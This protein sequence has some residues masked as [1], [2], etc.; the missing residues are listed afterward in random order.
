VTAA[1]ATARGMLDRIFPRGAIL[2]S[3]LSL[4]YFATGIIRNRVF[5]NTYG[6]G[7]ELDAYNAAFRIPEI[8]LDVLVAAGLTAP[9][10]PIYSRLRHDDGDE[11]ANDFGRTVLTG[12]VGLMTIAS[13]G[14]FIAA[15]WLAGVIAE[16]FDPATQDLY[17]QLLRIN[18]LAQVMFAASI[19]LGEILVAHR[20]F[21]FYALAP[22][23][24]TTGIIVGT[25]LF[26]ARFG[27]VASAWG[28][29]G[30]AAAHLAI[31]AIGTSR[32]SFR[33]RP[34]FVVR[35]AAFGE[36]LRLM[37]PRMFSVAIDP[38]TI[39]YFTRVAAGLG[40]GAVSALNFGLDYQVLPVSLIGVSFSLAVFPLLSAA[41]ADGD[42]SS[43]SAI[44]TKNL[45]TIGILTVLAAVAL[46]LLSAT[47]VHVLL[48]G[49]KFTAEDVAV[50][51][52]VVAAFALSVPF[53]ALAYPLSRGLYA[54]H[55]TLRQVLASF[56]G[57]G[58]VVLAT[59]LLVPEFGIVGI[60]LGYAAGVIAKDILLALFLAPRVRRI[61]VNPAG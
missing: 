38:L 58:A 56:A 34:A 12:A 19:A 52:A 27:I 33:I 14:I 36:F 49:G 16:G 40:V 41:Y 35:T 13:I 43:F 50:T 53:D 48:G 46:F 21:L 47:L 3:V 55:D 1:I 8:A 31:R 44:L 39:T 6:A 57:L 45:A 59:T 25:V 2:L 51:S 9:F 28:A 29:V 5:A 37:V 32:T 10:V 24:Y 22:I 18:C 30:G 15:P 60:P 4:G 26:A 23:L 54:T 7:A 11:P 17:I 61:G 20:R 42:R